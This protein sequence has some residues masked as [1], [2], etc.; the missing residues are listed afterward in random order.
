MAAQALDDLY[1]A[2]LQNAIGTRALDL[3]AFDEWS[4]REPQVKRAQIICTTLMGPISLSLRLVDDAGVPAL[5][6]T[7]LID[8]LA[9]HLHLRLGWQR[10]M[11]GR[12]GSG[13]DAMAL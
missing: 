3:H 5:I 13:C 10:A 4:Q 11:L 9:K 8:A 6:D 1:L 12:S 7:V 2:Y